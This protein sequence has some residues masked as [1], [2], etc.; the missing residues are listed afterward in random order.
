[1]GRQSHQTEWVSVTNMHKDTWFM[2]KVT[3]VE[4]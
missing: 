1:V 4:Q 3:P 2:R